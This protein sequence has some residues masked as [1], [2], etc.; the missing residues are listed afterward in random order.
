MRAGHKIQIQIHVPGQFF[1][2]GRPHFPA[3]HEALDVKALSDVG[4]TM[5]ARSPRDLDGSGG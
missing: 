2:L 5:A 3:L 4:T 1:D